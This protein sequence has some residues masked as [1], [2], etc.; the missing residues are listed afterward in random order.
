MDIEDLRDEKLP[1]P[2]LTIIEKFLSTFALFFF[3]KLIILLTSLSF[4]LIFV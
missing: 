1:G 2:R 4:S 3:K